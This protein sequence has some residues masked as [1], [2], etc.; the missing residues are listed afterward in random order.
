MNRKFVD[1]F[2]FQNDQLSNLKHPHL[3][4]KISRDSWAVISSPVRIAV[5]GE[6]ESII[7]L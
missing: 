3:L 6:V 7:P 2:N 5:S 4:S 1:L